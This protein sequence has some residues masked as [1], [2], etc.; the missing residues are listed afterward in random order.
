MRHTFRR[1]FSASRLN[2]EEVIDPSGNSMAAATA[3]LNRVSSEMAAGSGR[4]N[5]RFIGFLGGARRGPR[6][7]RPPPRYLLALVEQ[8]HMG[9]AA[10]RVSQ[11]PILT[12]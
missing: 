1:L 11:R 9:A 10:F 12:L 4:L 7:A 3:S 8:Q 5:A 2:P 6:R